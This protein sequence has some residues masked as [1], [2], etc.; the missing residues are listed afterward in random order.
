M[1]RQMGRSGGGPGK[2]G[3]R[4]W[5]AQDLGADGGFFFGAAFRPKAVHA[6]PE[7]DFRLPPIHLRRELLEVEFH[8]GISRPAMQGG[9]MNIPDV[10]LALGSGREQD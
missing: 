6:A 2:G 5:L 4:T 3:G 10:P 7:L 1:A 9:V 8:F